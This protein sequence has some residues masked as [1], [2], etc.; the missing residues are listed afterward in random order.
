MQKDQFVYGNVKIKKN[1]L[2]SIVYKQ[3]FLL[4]NKQR[5][6][7]SKKSSPISNKCKHVPDAEYRN[8]F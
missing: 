1:H 3:N 5:L 7:M 2:A 6:K 4:H 8:K